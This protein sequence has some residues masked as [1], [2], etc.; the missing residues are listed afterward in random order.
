M[1]IRNFNI[2]WT[3]FRPF[4]TNSILVIDTDAALSSAISRKRLQA[5]TRWNAEF[6]ER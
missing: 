1:V 2:E 3:R 4:E 6:A 5:I